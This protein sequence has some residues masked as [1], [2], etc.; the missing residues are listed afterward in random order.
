M[1]VTLKEIFNQE[2]EEFKKA[3]KSPE[4]KRQAVHDNVWKLQHCKTLWIGLQVYH[5]EDHHNEVKLMP[6]TCKSRFCPSCGYKANL[7]WLN[8]LMDRVLPCDHQHLIFSLPYELRELAKSNRRAIVGLMTK[9]TNQII[10]QFIKEHK[11]LDYLPGSFTVV[12]TFGSG[13][14]WHVHLHVLITAGGLKDNKWVENSYLNEKYLK[15][16]WKAKFLAGLRKLYHKGKLLDAVGKDPGQTFLQMLSSIWDK[17]WYVWINKADG[18]AS[19]SSVYIG[20]YVKRACISQKGIISYAPHKQIAWK[21]RKLKKAPD[22]CAYR[23]HPF[24]FINLLIQHIPD[25][26]DHQVFY[27]GLYSSYYKKRGYSKARKILEKRLKKQGS[28]ISRLKKIKLTFSKLMEWTHGTKPMHCSICGKKLVLS[29]IIFFN[30]ALPK[31]KD[32]LHNYTIKKYTL[33]KKNDTG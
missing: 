9:T 33:V 1:S 31:D 6:C 13:L 16:A 15:K 17:S 3:S 20:R 30:E 7:V 4:L 26:Y 2:W 14:K 24:S 25:R 22:I 8:N 28:I 10:R 27:Y 19:F 21:E 32:I 12:H 29:G 5:C 23:M 18:E 11:N